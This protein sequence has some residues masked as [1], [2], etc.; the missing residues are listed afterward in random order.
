MD[1]KQ[2]FQVLSLGVVLSS[3]Q[4]AGHN[5]GYVSNDT[6]KTMPLSKNA[7]DKFQMLYDTVDGAWFSLFLFHLYCFYGHLLC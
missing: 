2:L 5:M 3:C 7:N 1:L 6:D 4:H